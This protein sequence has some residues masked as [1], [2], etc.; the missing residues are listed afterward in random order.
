MQTIVE[1]RRALRAWTRLPALLLVAVAAHQLWLAHSAQL[2]AWSGGGF[3]M[4]STSDVWGR[5]HL[6]AYAISPGVRRELDVPKRLR[7]EMRQALALPTEAR[8]RALAHQL[9]STLPQD[10]AS[11]VE[12]VALSV[13]AKRFDAQTLAPS[14]V[15]LR[16]LRVPLRDTAP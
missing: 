2:S 7:E 8:L 9:V 10:E 4:F 5:R 16:S 6:H 1:P 3:G 14:G 13:Y 15:P 12:A 11:R